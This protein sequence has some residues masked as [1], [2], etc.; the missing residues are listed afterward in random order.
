MPYWRR[1]P[2]KVIRCRHG[3]I[4]ASVLDRELRV[5]DQD[6]QAKNLPG[7]SPRHNRV[8]YIPFLDRLTKRFATFQSQRTT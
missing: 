7:F 2:I 1:Q 4:E 5:C 8:P 6:L 3:P